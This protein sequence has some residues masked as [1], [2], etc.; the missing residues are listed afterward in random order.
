M[1]FALDTFPLQWNHRSMIVDYVPAQH[2]LNSPHR[3]TTVDYVPAQHEYN[4][5]HRSTTVDYVP[6]Q[7]EHNS[8]HRSTNSPL[9]AQRPIT[10]VL[11]M[12]NSYNYS[13][14]DFVFI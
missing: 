2:E 12:I 4:S 6:A 11:M 10:L 14:N 13:T 1:M 5:P 8:P 3:S 7:H 9:L